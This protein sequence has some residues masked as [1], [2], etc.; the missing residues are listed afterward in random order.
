MKI[1]LTGAGGLVGK[2]LAA[3]LPFEVVSFTHAELD[4]TDADAVKEAVRKTAPDVILNCAGLRNPASEEHPARAFS[5]NVSGVQNLLATGVKL[6]HLSSHTALEPTNGYA[7]TKRAAEAL[8][9]SRRHLIL[10]LPC[11]HTGTP[12]Y[13]SDIFVDDIPPLVTELA[14]WTGIYNV[15]D[16]HP[17]RFKD[18]IISVLERVVRKLRGPSLQKF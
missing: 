11:V 12:K 4:I 3:A 13:A 2:K 17:S 6:F 16:L 10:R 5:V 18:G 14:D 7:R 9:D 1:L 15:W 8:I